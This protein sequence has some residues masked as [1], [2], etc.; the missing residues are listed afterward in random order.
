MVCYGISGVV[1]SIEEK[2][3]IMG[4]EVYKLELS[5]GSKFKLKS[6]FALNGA[7][8]SVLV[9]VRDQSIGFGRGFFQVIAACTI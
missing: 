6:C 4:S 1:N 3:L 7:S 2:F 5:S 8:N 9:Y